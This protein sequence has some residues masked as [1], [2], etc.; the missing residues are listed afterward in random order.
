MK[1]C[2]EKIR[3]NDDILPAPRGPNDPD[4]ALGDLQLP[5]D[6]PAVRVSLRRG[7]SPFR[8][9]VSDPAPLVQLEDP[10]TPEIVHKLAQRVILVPILH[11]EMPGEFLQTD[12]QRRILRQEC[13]DAFLQ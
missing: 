5:D 9:D 7:G 6:P 4:P 10:A 13:Q 3:G 8:A 12:P 2:V 1:A 11:V